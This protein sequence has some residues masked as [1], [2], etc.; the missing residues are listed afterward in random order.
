MNAPGEL[1]DAAHTW[2]FETLVQPLLFA[3]GG[4]H[5]VEDAYLGTELALFGAVEIV[6][7][8]ALLRPL[9]ALTAVEARTDGQ[10]IRTDVIYTVLT[11]LG[12]LPLLFFFTLLPL[13]A[14]LDG[15]L[16]GIGL[17]RPTLETLIPPLT[18]HPLAAFFVYLVVLDL[19]AYWIHRWQHRF[20]W[21]W[22]LHAVHHSQ[23]QMTFWTDNRN[24]VFDDLIVALLTALVVRLIG[25][26]PGQFI[27]LAAGTALI[28][29]LSHAN[30]RFWFGSIGERLLVS[31]RFHRWHHAI[32]DGHEGRYRGINFAVLL[33]VWDRLFRT[34]DFRAGSPST[35]I[36]DQLGGANYGSGWWAQQTLGFRR[37]WQAMIPRT[38]RMNKLRP[39]KKR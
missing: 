13:E 38:G 5:L 7:M 37:L 17:V 32:G 6:V 28:E 25:V 4:M 36:R 34:A 33:P 8:L 16:H 14:Q 2:L 1:F 24:H 35:G 31:P 26:P 10:A 22:A 12:V 19:V 9:E 23:R 27:A 3:A 18:Q 20:G 15:L 29:N 11:R 21:W 30:T 39:L